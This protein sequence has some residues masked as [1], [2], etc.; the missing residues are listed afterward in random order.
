MIKII[1]YQ[2]AEQINLK[3]FKE[4]YKGKLYSSSSV[5]LF[6]FSEKTG[7]AIYLLSYGVV[8]FAN[9]EAME[10]SKFIDYL[11]LY[12]VNLLDRHYTEDIIIHRNKKLSFS[13]N[14]VHLTDTGPESI[15]IVMLNVAQSACLDYYTNQSQ[16]LLDETTRY[17]NELEKYGRLKISQKNLLKFIGKTLNIKNRIIENLYIF[18]VPDTWED[19]Y[20]DKVNTG[21][22][23]TFDINKRFRE[24]E[25]MLKSVE[26]NLSVF[27]ELAQQK[28]S[29]MMEL[30][31]IFL[32]LVEV[33]N[34]LVSYFIY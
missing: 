25:H 1:A 20:K 5:D 10:M 12:S 13:Y 27:T 11:K 6:Y 33:L 31:I 22:E 30:I 28:T 2:L 16:K 18:D 15:R 8:V 24:I 9:H 34:M 26:S 32:I 7:K 29:N 17:S 4:A 3:R 19:E 21:M 23:N 14:D